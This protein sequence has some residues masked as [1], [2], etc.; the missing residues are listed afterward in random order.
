MDFDLLDKETSI[1][2]AT[3]PILDNVRFNEKNSVKVSWRCA[4]CFSVDCQLVVNKYG[5]DEV[6]YANKTANPSRWEG[7]RR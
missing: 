4:L 2:L 5:S 3:F 6:V 7:Q 1:S